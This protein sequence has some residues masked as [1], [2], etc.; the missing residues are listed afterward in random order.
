MVT[1]CKVAGFLFEIRSVD[2]PT[3]HPAIF[4]STTVHVHGHICSLPQ[5]DPNDG[6][7]VLERGVQLLL[8]ASCQLLAQGL[9]CSVWGVGGRQLRKTQPA[10]S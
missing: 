4:E 8:P 9:L 2:L 5:T 6:H 3:P 1:G 7:L 10:S